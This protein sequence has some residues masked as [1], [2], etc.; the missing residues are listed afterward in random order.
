MTEFFEKGDWD[1]F[2]E[3]EKGGGTS[4]QKVVSRFR[5]HFDN[6]Y[7]KQVTFLAPSKD[8]RI[9]EVGCGTAYG[10]HRLGEMGYVSF[11]MDYSPQA[12]NFWDR[13][14][15]NFLIADGFHIPFKSDSFDLVWNAGVLEHFSD[16]QPML[17]E[18]IRVCKPGGI[19][20]VIVPYIFDVLAYMRVYGEEK[21]YTKSDVKILLRNL[22]DVGVKVFYLCAGM[23]I[24]GWGRKREGNS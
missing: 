21:I 20:C 14:A 7:V 24:C 5:T 11:A 10:T 2:W 16:P 23:L 9:L 12:A 8:A 3:A 1:R 15:A 18:M 6:E 22:D 17:N 13:K 19:V 4:I